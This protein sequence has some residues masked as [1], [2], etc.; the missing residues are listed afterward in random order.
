MTPTGW[1][2]PVHLAFVAASVAAW[3][4][5]AVLSLVPGAE[6]PHTGLPGNAEHAIA[7]A[8]AAL[9]TRLGFPKA[10]SAW[11]AAG[12]C[13]MAGIFEICQTWIP[14]RGPGVGNWVASSIGA[15][16]GL[17]CAKTLDL[18]IRRR[19]TPD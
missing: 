7:Y 13:A 9:V 1:A 3:V 14:G 16:T 5:L 12:F 10:R 15:A 2:K 17:V 18:A 4:V 11:I 8:L 6:R 19:E